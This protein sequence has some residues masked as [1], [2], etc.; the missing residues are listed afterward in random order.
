M[1]TLKASLIASAIGFGVWIL[2]IARA[3]W[4]AHPQLASCLLTIAMT[5]VLMYIWSDPSQK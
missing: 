1:K 3:I 2:G 5:F 4:P